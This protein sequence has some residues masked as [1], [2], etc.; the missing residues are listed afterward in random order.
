MTSMALRD[1][2]ERKFVPVTE[3]GCWLWTASVREKGYGQF[4]VGG[5]MVGAHRF[6]FE[7]YNGP[8]PG[9]AH[10]L[11]RCDTPA[12]VN[13]HHL[14]LGTNADNVADMVKK[15][16]NRAGVVRGERHGKSKLNEDQVYEIRTRYRFDNISQRQLADEYGVSCSTISDLLNDKTWGHLMR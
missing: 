5:K 10:V 2:F 9:G 16:R 11:H 13:P 1:R 3:S 15:G 14:F 7:L 4:N 6:S 12:C 8:I